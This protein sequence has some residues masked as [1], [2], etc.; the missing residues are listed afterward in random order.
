MS[1]HFKVTIQDYNYSIS[2]DSLLLR[3]Y[4][5]AICSA[6]GAIF[7][8][9]FLG[10]FLSITFWICAIQ[11]ASAFRYSILV[12]QLCSSILYI[13]P[14]NTYSDITTKNGTIRSKGKNH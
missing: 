5:Y 8:N 11:Y 10:V 6:F 7:K 1:N 3:F 12:T 2:F 9:R 4:F 13:G 14:A